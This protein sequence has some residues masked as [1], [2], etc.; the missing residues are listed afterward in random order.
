MDRWVKKCAIVTGAAS[1]IGKAITI[2]LLEKGVNVLALDVKTEGL[3]SLSHQVKLGP[4]TKLHVMPCDVTNQDHLDQAFQYAES[5][6]NGV[7]IMVNNAGVF[8][9]TRVIESDRAT[10]ERLLNINVLANAV[11]TNRAVRSMRQRNIEGHIFNINSVL[12]REI[13]SSYLLEKDGWN[14]YPACKHGTVALTHTVRRELAAIK[15]PIRITG[16]NPGFVDTNI[17]SHVPRLVE[18]FKNIP[19][20]R[21]EDVADAVIYALSTRPEVQITELTIQRTG[22]V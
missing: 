3:S 5:T 9:N 11:C 13:P 19:T 14:L 16:I 1:G 8:D 4:S 10:F 15:A 6:W 12:G 20:L 17:G 7:D 22:E 21:P 18:A 2:A